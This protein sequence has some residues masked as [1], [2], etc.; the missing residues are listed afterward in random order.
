MLREAL[1]DEEV[2]TRVRAA[3]SGDFQAESV[4]TFPTKPGEGCL[5]F[6]SPLSCASRT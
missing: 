3:V 1:R 4:N 6:I 2:V 5:D